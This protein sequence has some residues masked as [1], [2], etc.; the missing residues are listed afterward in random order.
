MSAIHTTIEILTPTERSAI[1][2][3]V[4]ALLKNTGMR[5]ESSFMLKVLENAGCKVDYEAKIVRYPESLLESTIEL[6]AKEHL[7]QKMSVEQRN[8]T[9]CSFA[10]A[11]GGLGFLDWPSGQIKKPCAKDAKFLLQLCEAF[12][13]EFSFTCMPL[14]Y[15]IDIDGKE[16]DPRLWAIRSA[17]L[18]VKN[19]S[20]AKYHDVNSILELNYLIEL[21]IVVKGSREEYM[22]APILINCQCC[23]EPLCFDNPWAYILAEMAKRG[24]KCDIGVMPISGASSPVTPGA[25]V[26][27]AIAEILAVLTAV[28]A[29]NPQTPTGYVCL[30]GQINMSTTNSMMF[31][32][33]SSLQDSAVV[34]VCTKLY[35][36]A[37]N[38]HSLY[39]DGT[40]PTGQ[41]SIERA[42]GYFRN[43]AIGSKDIR[44]PG[45]I[46]QS[47]LVSPEQMII[48][49]D[50]GRWVDRF[51][52]GLEINENTLAL[53]EICRVGPG[54][55]FLST[56]HTF[57]HYKNYLWE[58]SVFSNVGNIPSN[59]N[60][61]HE[62]DLMYKANERI[63]QIMKNHTSYAL[64]KDKQREIDRIVRTCENEIINALKCGKLK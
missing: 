1:H 21:G 2:S 30:S 57:E 32:P 16:F 11:G 40:I 39:V 60:E 29:I 41:C 18:L 54:G 8:K 28:K 6:I 22:K 14:I 27:I 51:F 35:N 34:E 13:D 55:N 31:S 56:D 25:A 59:I 52:R 64:D 19:S 7:S 50:I 10:L 42:L 38:C 20:K 49:M 12:K 3:S 36:W 45:F 46:G 4:M 33:L 37:P 26:V 53:E 44:F 48:D 63:K 58:P 24:L 61:L 62:Q 9:R 17:G 43:A 47:K 5:I 15:L 23:R